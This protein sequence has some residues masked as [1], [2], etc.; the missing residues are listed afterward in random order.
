MPIVSLP[1][2]TGASWVW[3]R[4]CFQQA[5]GATEVISRGKLVG[6]CLFLWLLPCVFP[7]QP[8]IK[9]PPLCKSVREVSHTGELRRFYAISKQTNGWRSY[10]IPLPVTGCSP[11]HLAQANTSQAGEK[12]RKGC[13]QKGPDRRMIKGKLVIA[14][15]KITMANGSQKKL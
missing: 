7:H 8:Q 11:V 9:Q 15:G 4:R 5:G 2:S 1:T 3:N 13:G 10:L 6:V 14:E 12:R